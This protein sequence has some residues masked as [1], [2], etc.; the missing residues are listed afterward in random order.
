MKIGLFLQHSAVEISN[1]FYKSITGTSA[2]EVALTFHC[3]K[4]FPCDHIVLQDINLVGNEGEPTT[5]SCKN[6]KGIAAGTVYPRPCFWKKGK[7]PC[8][9]WSLVACVHFLMNWI[10]I[11]FLLPM[12][13]EEQGTIV[14]FHKWGWIFVGFQSCL[15]LSRLVIGNAIVCCSWDVIKYSSWLSATHIIK[16]KCF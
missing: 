11:G 1:V 6:V 9:C 2:S 4:N 12:L 16:I 7:C 8:I 15:I 10:W 13:G 3:S 5:G 14:N